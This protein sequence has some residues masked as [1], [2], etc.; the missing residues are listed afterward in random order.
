MKKIVF[1]GAVMASVLA[2][3]QDPTKVDKKLDVQKAEP[4]YQ[5]AA[6]SDSAVYSN[7]LKIHWLHR[8]K[9]DSLETG[10]LVE[11]EYKVFLSDGKLIEGS[12]KLGGTFPFMVGFGMQTKGWDFAMTKLA[13]GD[14]VEVY[15][16]A[17]LARGEKGIEGLIPPNSANIL[18]LKI[19][20]KRNADKVIDGTK[21]Y[22][23]AQNRKNKTVFNDTN[24]ITF[25]TMIST[26]SNPMYFNTFRSNQ[27]F[28]MK[29]KDAGVVPGL[30]KA[31][32]NAKKADRLYVVIPPGE[33]YG[34]K[35][36]QDLVKPN[37]PLFYNIY[38]MDVF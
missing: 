6:T 14:E 17:E 15:I 30:K 16:P 31:L 10:D 24:S 2:C 20:E 32:N 26:P 35:G 37:E 3:K 12:H 27:P 21:L 1:L 5:A 11:I 38:V 9:G 7:G 4:Q 19:V 28:T 33:G 34:N 23:I 25:H 18:Y 8:G 13:V 36:Y 29:M 22:Y